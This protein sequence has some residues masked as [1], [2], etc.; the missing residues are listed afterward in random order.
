LIS[1]NILVNKICVVKINRGVN[2]NFVFI[3][4]IVEPRK[5]GKWFSNALKTHNERLKGAARDD[6][7]D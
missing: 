7:A 6:G 3:E 2:K 4:K 1:Q 5:N